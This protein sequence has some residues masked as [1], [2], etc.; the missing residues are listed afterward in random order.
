[1]DDQD[2]DPAITRRRLLA[3]G[4]G[5]ALAVAGGGALL[6]CGGS[7]AAPVAKAPRVR[8]LP[9]GR[10]EQQHRWDGA[11]KRDGFGNATAPR[12][13]RL[14]MLGIEGAPGVAAAA[15]LEDALRAVEASQ[16]AGP[17]GLLLL[18]GWGPRWFKAI[19]EESPVPEPVALTPDEAPDLDAYAACIHL[20]SDD[21]ARLDAAEKLVRDGIGTPFVLADRRA[22]F[23][24]RGLPRRLGRGA[25]GIPT[26]QPRRD[27]PLFM[28]FASG[29]TRNQARETDVEIADG[30]WKGAT[31][32]HVSTLSLALSSWYGSL[33]EQQRAH[34]MF[35]PKISLEAVRNPGEGLDPQPDPIGTA[36]ESGLVGHAQALA[37]A[38]RS[39]RPRILRRDFN[40]LDGKQPLVHFVALQRSIDDF[41]ETRSA[42]AAARAVSAD[43]RVQPQVNNG[44]NEWITTRNR[45]NYLVPPRTRRTCPLLPGWDE[46]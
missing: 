33:S 40:G 17:E 31:T 12:F 36:R 13:D 42:M 10:P 30:P 23:T 8:P 45:A 32:M 11:L 37:V 9:A 43:P 44:I 34:R 26:G 29:F 38:R 18:V 14:L 5:A 4:G 28:G 3:V 22:G 19:G 35:G 15:R 27:S 41:V 46:V 6:G 7:S 24:G 16:P 39:G 25:N 1:M 20:A 21:P 2:L